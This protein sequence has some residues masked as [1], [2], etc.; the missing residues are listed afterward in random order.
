M[1]GYAVKPLGVLVI[2]IVLLVTTCLVIRSLLRLLRL[3][4]EDPP[5]LTSLR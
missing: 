5:D 3:R 2:G 1:N 4:G